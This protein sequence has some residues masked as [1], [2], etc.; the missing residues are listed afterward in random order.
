MYFETECV[1]AVQ[2]HP[3]VADLGT[4]R[5]RVCNLLLV[6]NILGPI[7]PRFKDRPIAGFLLKT[8]T[9]HLFHPADFGVTV[10]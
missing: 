2:G 7:L 10:T 1:M 6:I 9:P 8:A 5:K 3:K 4:N